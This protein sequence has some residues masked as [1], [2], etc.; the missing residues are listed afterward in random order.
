IVHV[1]APAG[2]WYE[3]EPGATRRFVHGDFLQFDT[4]PSAAGFL[5][6]NNQL[7]TCELAAPAARRIAE[8]G[9]AADARQA[10]LTWNRFGGMLAPL[11]ELLRVA[12]SGAV[13]VLGVESGGQ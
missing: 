5:C 10:A 3:I 13:A 1:L 2:S 9:L 7:C 4:T 11:C 8:G 6:E 12:P